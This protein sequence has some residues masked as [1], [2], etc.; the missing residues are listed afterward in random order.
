MILLLFQLFLWGKFDSIKQTKL[1]SRLKTATLRSPVT[2]QEMLLEFFEHLQQPQLCPSLGN[3]SHTLLP[4]IGE[5]L[6]QLRLVHFWRMRCSLS[7]WHGDLPGLGPLSQSKGFLKPHRNKDNSA[8]GFNIL[9]L[10][11]VQLIS[12]D[13]GSKTTQVNIQKWACLS[14]MSSESWPGSL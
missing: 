14:L 4:Y 10:L 6:K 5:L 12:A 9:R 11:F 13:L 7:K 2:D 8:Q 3:V 1:L